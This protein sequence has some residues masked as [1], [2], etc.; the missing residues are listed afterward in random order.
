M[1]DLAQHR[2]WSIC[3]VYSYAVDRKNNYGQYNVLFCFF[4]N[5]SFVL[6]NEFCQLLS[7]IHF[8]CVTYCHTC[9]GMILTFLKPPG[10]P[11]VPIPTDWLVRS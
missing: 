6:E 4:Q 10:V 2:I 5:L 3:F 7:A 1:K 9:D 8:H 11:F